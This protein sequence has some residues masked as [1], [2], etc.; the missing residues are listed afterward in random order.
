MPLVGTTCISDFVARLDGNARN[1][2]CTLEV[3]CPLAKE[4]SS[5]K[6]AM[7]TVAKAAPVVYCYVVSQTPCKVV[8]G[9][10]ADIRR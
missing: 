2:E 9:I 6:F 3:R 1:A 5:N 8:L 4:K 10:H 7:P